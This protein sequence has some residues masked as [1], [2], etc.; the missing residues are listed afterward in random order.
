L[1][2]ERIGGGGTG[3][4]R[5]EDFITPGKLSAKIFDRIIIKEDDIRGRPRGS[6]AELIGKGIV[7][8]SQIAS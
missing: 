4:R 7:Q 3:D 6:A 1:V 2:G 5:D 8:L